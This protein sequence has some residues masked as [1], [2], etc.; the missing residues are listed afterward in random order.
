MGWLRGGGFW[1]GGGEEAYGMV[2]GREA[3]GM[4]EGRGAYG[5]VKGRGMGQDKG[6]KKE[7]TLFVFFSEDL[8]RP[9]FIKN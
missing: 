4:V 1:D 6:R 2:E 7:T 3:E 9:T 5:M 8:Y